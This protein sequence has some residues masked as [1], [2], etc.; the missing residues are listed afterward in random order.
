MENESSN[1]NN[2]ETK[3]QKDER[4]FQRALV[5]FVAELTLDKIDKELEKQLSKLNFF[6]LIHI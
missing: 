3:E 2:N 5:A 4:A 1:P 6:K